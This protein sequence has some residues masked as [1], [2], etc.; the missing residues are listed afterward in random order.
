M[1]GQAQDDE[2]WEQYR[3]PKEVKNEIESKKLAI[4]GKARRIALS[5]ICGSS[6]GALLFFGFK[7]ADFSYGTEIGFFIATIVAFNLSIIEIEYLD[8]QILPN[9][10]RW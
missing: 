9:M 4:E 3:K 7:T 6:V 2:H 5:L 10:I 1:S 8:N